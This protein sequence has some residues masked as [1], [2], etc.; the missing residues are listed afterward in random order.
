MY[1]FLAHYINMETDEHIT[2]PINFD[3]Q[4]FS[5]EKEIYMYA[6]GLAYDMMKEFEIFDNIEF[7]AC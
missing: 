3:G 6:M 4:F 1:Y 2:R 7:L 5:N